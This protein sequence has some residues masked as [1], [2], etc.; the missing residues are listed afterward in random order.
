[1]ATDSTCYK[2]LYNEDTGNG[3][4]LTCHQEVSFQYHALVGQKG[5]VGIICSHWG[6]W[7]AR[8]GQEGAN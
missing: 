2:A 4:S 7:A 1:M 6:A 8:P 3:K 5:H